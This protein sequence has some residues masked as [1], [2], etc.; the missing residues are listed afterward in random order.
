MNDQEM[1]GR[2]KIPDVMSSTDYSSSTLAYI[3]SMPF[4]RVK[5]ASESGLKHQHTPV[6]RNI[7]RTKLRLGIYF[8]GFSPSLSFYLN[9]PST[10]DIINI[11]RKI[12]K[13]SS[14][15]IFNNFHGD[16]RNKVNSDL[17]PRRLKLSG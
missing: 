13:G 17:P 3:H 12:Y 4:C 11:N 10:V 15:G 6:C 1:Q 16:E 7:E 5:E 8:E 14:S 2:S 9:P